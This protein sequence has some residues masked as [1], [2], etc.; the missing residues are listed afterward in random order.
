MGG[1][2]AWRRW[3]SF[4]FMA[5]RVHKSAQTSNLTARSDGI[6]NQT[7]SHFSKYTHGMETGA[8][9][10]AHYDSYCIANAL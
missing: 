7:K 6:T 4:F 8:M 1:R 5:G 2:A 3:L 10:G 9:K